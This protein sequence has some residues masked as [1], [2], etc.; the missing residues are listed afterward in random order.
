MCEEFLAKQ[1]YDRNDQIAR[2]LLV[3]AS[4]A[5]SIYNVRLQDHFVGR[6]RW[7]ALHIKCALE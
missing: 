1:R 2:E 6:L 5:K 3:A 4:G 7:K